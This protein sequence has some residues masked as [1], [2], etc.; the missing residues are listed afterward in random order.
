ML[1]R[2]ELSKARLEQPGGVEGVPAHG[3]SWNLPP[4]QGAGAEVV[5]LGLPGMEFQ[6]GGNYRHSQRSPLLLQARGFLNAHKTRSSA[7]F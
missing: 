2:M 5:V 6:S 4:I 3:I 7:Q 1:G